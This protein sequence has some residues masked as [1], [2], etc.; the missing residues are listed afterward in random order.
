VLL[1]V[2]FS[3]DMVI[4]SQTGAESGG[5]QN[6][7]A[8]FWRISDIW[9]DRKG[10]QGLKWGWIS[11]RVGTRSKTQ[12]HCEIRKG[13]HFLLLSL[14]HLIGTSLWE[15]GVIAIFLISLLDS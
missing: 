15:G 6:K 14:G 10:K 3:R 9:A 2:I 13:A 7:C 4:Y 12:L 8:G 5:S 1:A 11:A